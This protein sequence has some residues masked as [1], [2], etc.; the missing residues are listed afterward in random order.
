MYKILCPERIEKKGEEY[1][2]KRGYH[3]V[4]Q[5]W[6]PRHWNNPQPLHQYRMRLSEEPTMPIGMCRFRL[7]QML[8]HRD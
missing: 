5:L 8:F 6:H 4:K 7:N 3:V 1:L 2:L